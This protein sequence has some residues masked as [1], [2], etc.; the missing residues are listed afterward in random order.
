MNLCRECGHVKLYLKL[1]EI[2]RKGQL[3]LEVDRL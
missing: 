2:L 1:V 3:V